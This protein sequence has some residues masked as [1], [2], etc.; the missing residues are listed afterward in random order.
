MSEPKVAG[1]T[2]LAIEVESGQAY[3]W[4]ACGLSKKQPFC[5]G[6]HG[7]TDFRPVLFKAEKTQT[8]Y[9][10]NCKSTKKAPLCDGSHKKLNLK[11]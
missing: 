7:Q 1:S 5:D 3:M 11:S 8:L 10:C 2:P 9:F 6:S 4:C